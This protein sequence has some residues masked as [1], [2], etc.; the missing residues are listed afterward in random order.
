MPS[1]SGLTIQL[2]LFPN[3]LDE[4]GPRR[5]VDKDRLPSVSVTDDIFAV[6]R[7]FEQAERMG[8]RSVQ[9]GKEK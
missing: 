3:S 2:L 5:K 7:A 6:R 1:H 4:D 9:E 8:Q